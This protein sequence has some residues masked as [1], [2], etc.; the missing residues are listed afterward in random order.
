MLVVKIELRFITF[1]TTVCLYMKIFCQRGTVYNQCIHI[2]TEICLLQFTEGDQYILTCFVLRWLLKSP[3]IVFVS[4]LI[5]LTT[6]Y[7]R[8]RYLLRKVYIR[9]IYIMMDGFGSRWCTGWGDEVH[10]DIYI[11]IP[12]DHYCKIIFHWFIVFM[13]IKVRVRGDWPAIIW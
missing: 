12:Y 4:L 1:L 6:E 8:L 10:S 11:C 9:E 5:D 3:T 13:L 2:K 7:Y